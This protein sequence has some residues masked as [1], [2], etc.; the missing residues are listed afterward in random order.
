MTD[1]TLAPLVKI[2]KI[3]DQNLREVLNDLSS[4]F[5]MTEEKVEHLTKVEIWGI[6]YLISRYCLLQDFMGS[7]LIDETLIRLREFSENMSMTDKI[8]KLERLGLI[9]NVKLWDQMRKLRNSLTHE[10]PDHP[11]L[12]ARFLNQAYP[13]SFELLHS[14]LMKLEPTSL[15]AEPDSAS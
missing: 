11:E 10:Y 13:L 9:K 14:L 3:H 8:R 15:D 5:P 1:Q 6:G 4:L 7:N 2:A 12:I